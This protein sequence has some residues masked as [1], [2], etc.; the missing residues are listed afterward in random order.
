M[1]KLR[2]LYP[3][4]DIFFQSDKD[5]PTLVYLLHFHAPYKHA[6]HY[7]GSCY[8]RRFVARILEHENGTNG[9]KLMQVVRKAGISWF[10]AHTWNANRDFEMHLK[11]HVKHTSRIC[12]VCNGQMTYDD[13]VK[14]PDELPF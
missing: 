4:S 6:R 10:V 1:Q 3:E 5:K 14:L 8:K 11:T 7:I 2:K 9:S 13:G 12:P